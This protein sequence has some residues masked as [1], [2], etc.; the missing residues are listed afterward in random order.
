MWFLYGWNADFCHYTPDQDQVDCVV[1][2]LRCLCVVMRHESLVYRLGLHV[3]HTD[4]VPDRKLMATRAASSLKHA[5]I[6]IA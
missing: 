5:E 1:V 3:M 6:G 2:T 4:V